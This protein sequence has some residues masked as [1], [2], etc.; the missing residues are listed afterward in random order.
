[1]YFK[2]TWSSFLYDYASNII[3]HLGFY[4]TLFSILGMTF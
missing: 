4:F 3:T 2:V 1:M